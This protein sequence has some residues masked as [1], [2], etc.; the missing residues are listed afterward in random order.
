L[1]ILRSMRDTL[2]Q[3]EERYYELLRGQSPVQRLNTAVML[4]QTVRRLAESAILAK[5]PS[6]SANEIRFH[7]ANRLYGEG[8]ARRLFPRM[9]GV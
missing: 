3:A 4:T 5:H 7:L 8:V 9:E 6:A 1:F 2:P